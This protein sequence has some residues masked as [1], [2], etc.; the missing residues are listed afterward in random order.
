MLLQLDDVPV[1]ILRVDAYR[2]AVAHHAID[3]HV[4]VDEHFVKI[5]DV[6]EGRAT[7]RDLLQDIDIAL[8][9]AAGREEKLMIFNRA[10]LCGH[11]HRAA[12]A[13]IAHLQSENI[14]IESHRTFDVA[15]VNT[16]MP[17]RIDFR[18]RTSFGQADC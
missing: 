6:F 11:E 10:I 9:V 5:F 14:A 4:V 1:G 12:R 8:V 16:D 17:Q 18:H 3:R 13:S 15:H 7:E 2:I